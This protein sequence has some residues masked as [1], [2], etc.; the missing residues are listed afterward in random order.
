MRQ[1]SRDNQH[2]V[3][4]GIGQL[5]NLEHK[6]GRNCKVECTR[7]MPNIKHRR[8]SKC[9]Y[10]NKMAVPY[11]QSFVTGTF[12][13]YQ[14]IRYTPGGSLYQKVSLYHVMGLSYFGIAMSFSLF[15]SEVEN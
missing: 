11:E 9:M 7:Q 4:V 12:V 2:N 15:H 8:Y 1:A 3:L 13:I 14:E 6:N 5:A 10:D